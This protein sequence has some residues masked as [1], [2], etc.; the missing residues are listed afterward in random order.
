MEIKE[1]YNEVFEEDVQVFRPRGPFHILDKIQ[2]QHICLQNS[3][4][5]YLPTIDSDIKACCSEIVKSHHEALSMKEKSEL[6]IA[7]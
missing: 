4:F 7:M 3:L 6:L 5:P 2:Q 1:V